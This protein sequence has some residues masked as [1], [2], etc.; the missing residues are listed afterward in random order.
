MEVFLEEQN[1][2]NFLSNLPDRIRNLIS[3]IVTV[4]LIAM[5]AMLLYISYRSI[6]SRYS[7]V[8]ESGFIM[9][10]TFEIKV[11]GAGSSGHVKAALERV[12]EIAKLID[13][14]AQDSEITSINNMAGI[15]PVS[16]SQDTF[17]IIDKALS[18]A[19]R[20]G[21]AYDLTIGPLVDIWAPTFRT[22]R[23]IPSGNELVYA[24]HLVN[25]GNVVMNHSDQTVKLMYPGMKID[26]GS[27]ARGY[28]ISKARAILVDRNVK[29]ALITAGSCIAAIGDNRGRPW[30]VAIRHPRRPDE[31]IGV[32]DL[33]AGQALSTVG[34]YDNYFEVNGVRYHHLLNPA[35]GMPADSCQSVTIVCNDA[36]Q[37]EALSTAV[38]VMGP[39][40][41]MALV[42]GFP[43][44]YAVIVDKTGKTTVSDGLKLER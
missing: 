6:V 17:D 29:S 43:E 23:D 15:S 30:Q 3:N 25:Y 42:K 38:F 21:G 10:T 24:Q 4:I 33:Q 1:Y 40:R 44:T 8:N 28:A 13:Y 7:G 39:E 16:V 37:A 41:G 27:I 9:N 11:N 20:S 26:L 34:D 18:Y 12:R 36:I 35:T 14:D 5:L 2:S 31:Q 32:V 22:R 19:R